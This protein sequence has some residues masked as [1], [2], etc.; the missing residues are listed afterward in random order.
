MRATSSRGAEDVTTVIASAVQRFR[1]RGE[2]GLATAPE[3]AEL[4]PVLVVAVSEP[5]SEERDTAGALFRLLNRSA[6]PAE[7]VIV[8]CRCD[9]T[10]VD[11]GLA[12]LRLSVH[13]E[14]PLRFAVEILVPAGGVLGALD[15]AADGGMVAITS[16]SRMRRLKEATGIR[17]VLREVVL[18]GCAPPPRLSSLVRSLRAP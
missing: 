18:L 12:L 14:A 1:P 9:W 11:P 17:D 16:P 8:G 13:A 7:A 6:W 3:A 2:G 5:S 4:W 10:V 15:D